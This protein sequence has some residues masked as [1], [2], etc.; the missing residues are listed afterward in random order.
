MKF[1]QFEIYPLSDGYFRLDGGAMFGVVP[2]VIWEKTNPPDERN[3]I[4]LA[5]GVLLV[6]AHGEN[7]LV[8]TGIGSKGDRKFRDIYGVDRSPSL[9]ISLAGLGLAP[10]NITRVINTH[11]HFDHAGGNTRRTP[12]GEIVPAFPRA[13]YYIQRQEWE[14]AIHPN[15]RTRGSYLMENY[16]VLEKRGMLFFLEGE[17]AL[18]DGIR[19]IETPGHTEHHQSVILSS[20]GKR[21]IFLGDLIPTVSHLPYPFIMGYDLFP[22]TT[23]RTKKRILQQAFEEEWLLI[24]QHDPR[25]R[26]G[27]LREER[28]GFILEEV[29]E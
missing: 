28:N 17:T 1:G 22:L 20:E 8:D 3:R 12:G 13:S 26:M 23:L 24:F 6:Q 18:L 29:K 4:Y 16:E 2:R 27:Y 9:E 10:E 7:I 21:A 11:F 25:M 14:A 5:L 19:V 15:E